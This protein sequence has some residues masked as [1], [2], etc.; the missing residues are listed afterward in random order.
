MYNMQI[1]ILGM[2]TS[3]EC[4]LI[5]MAI[6]AILC[7]ALLCGTSRLSAKEG[8]AVIGANVDYV[9]GKDVIG[10]KWTKN[11]P[12]VQSGYETTEG[13]KLPLPEGQLFFLANNAFKPECCT[14]GS[15]LAY[16]SSSGC[17]CVT[18]EQIDYI[19]KRGGNRNACGGGF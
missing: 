14:P 1:N 17:A 3:V 18:K 15:P 7:C 5:S 4:I 8:M 10:N 9:M 6:G 16:S 19:N 13:P 2:K 11:P 12:A